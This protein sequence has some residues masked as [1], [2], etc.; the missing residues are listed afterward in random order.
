MRRVCGEPRTRITLRLGHDLITHPRI[1]WPGQR[2]LQQHPGITL[3]Q[4]LDHELRQPGQLRARNPD[5]EHQADRP[6]SS[7]GR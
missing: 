5:R 6:T 3:P 7:L 1:Q 4:P 2:R